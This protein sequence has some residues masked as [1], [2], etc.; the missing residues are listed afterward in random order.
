MVQPELSDPYS[1]LRLSS[2]KSSLS[3]G[4][5]PRQDSQAWFSD[6]IPGQGREQ[7]GGSTTEVRSTA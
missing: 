1:A 3:S 6:G 7:H 2:S 4:S 5:V